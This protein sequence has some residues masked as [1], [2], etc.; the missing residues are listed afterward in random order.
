MDSQ[1]ADVQDPSSLSGP[2][3]QDAWRRWAAREVSKRALLAQYAQDG[4][5]GSLF[6]APPVAGHLQNPCHTAAGKDV[7]DAKTAEDW[8]EAYTSSLSPVPMIQIYESLLELKDGTRDV[9]LVP[10][11]TMTPEVVLEGLY[12]LANEWFESIGNKIGVIDLTAVAGGLVRFYDD[13]LEPQGVERDNLLI[14][15]HA[16]GIFVAENLRRSAG[17]TPASELYRRRSVLHAA[18]ILAVTKQIP[19]ARAG[20]PHINLPAS[21]YAGGKIL[22]DH[23][24]VP[25]ASTEPYMD[26]DIA[27]DWV[28]LGTM[29]LTMTGPGPELSASRSPAHHFL[30]WGGSLL[31]EGLPLDQHH[32]SCLTTMLNVLGEVWPR[33]E[34]FSD[35]LRA[36]ASGH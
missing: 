16:I 5:L 15:W 1:S 20:R 9:P 12:S 17:S 28:D 19:I 23:L 21:I 35:L 29:G 24:A 18:S 22:L 3:L 2:S 10:S 33:S 34:I 25:S 4:C 27:V 7:F 30:V 8:L 14:R 13:F 31:V 32:L 11:S 36:A 6:G 26:V